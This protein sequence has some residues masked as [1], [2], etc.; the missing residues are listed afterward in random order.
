[1]AYLIYNKNTLTAT[2]RVA[3]LEIRS[4]NEETINFYKNWDNDLPFVTQNSTQNSYRRGGT[5]RKIGWGCAALFKKPLTYFRPKSVIFPTQFQ[6]WSKIWYPISDLKPWSP[7][8][9]RSMWQAVKAR[10]DYQPPPTPQ[11][12]HPPLWYF[13]YM[14]NMDF[15][16][17]QR[18][19]QPWIK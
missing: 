16:F 17:Q 11:T 15:S 12:P 3:C 1:M 2:F 10:T 19:V 5:S 13:K 8:G 6:T 18:S 9:D 7:V 14:F 4:R